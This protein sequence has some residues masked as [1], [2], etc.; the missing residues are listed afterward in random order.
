M[1]MIIVSYRIP[2]TLNE[3]YEREP[4]KSAG[5]L[6]TAVNAYINYLK[7]QKIFDKVIWAGW[8]G[9]EVA[10]SKKDVVRNNI[11]KEDDVYP[12]FISNELLD[13]FYSGFCNKTI[14]PLFHY[15]Y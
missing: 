4:I 2:I 3:N 5:G 6:V 13:A 8:A 10:E 11:L 1:K 14:W 9:R 7:K 15:F 12:V